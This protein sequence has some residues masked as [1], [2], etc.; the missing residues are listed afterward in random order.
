MSGDEVAILVALA[1]FAALIKSVA[2]M[3]YPIIILP[4]LALFIDIADAIVV[5][6]PANLAMNVMLMWN[7][8]AEARSS[9]T[10][11]RFLGWSVVFGI[12]GSLA[13]PVLSER[14]LRLL[15]VSIVGLYLLN[16]LRAPQFSL[17]PDRGRRL[18]PLAGSL[19]GLSQGA[20][21]VSGPIVTPWFLSQ[22]LERD[23]FVFSI[24]A[25]FCLSGGAQLVGLAAQGLYTDDVLG[26]SLLII[27]VSLAAIPIGLGVRRRVST[28]SFERLV[29][30]ILVFSAVTI[31]ARLF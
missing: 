4:I 11:R 31:L 19:A 8:R 13:V 15:L 12:I 2:G 27:P 21:G 30:A 14:V 16:R 3:G 20:T 5:V 24:T 22:G 28:S 1:V 26:P 6:A 7:V 9:P 10:L 18:A 17:S 29:V 23:A 25:A